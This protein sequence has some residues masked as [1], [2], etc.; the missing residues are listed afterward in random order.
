MLKSCESTT[1]A[2]SVG[3]SFFLLLMVC[4]VGC[5]WHWKRSNTQQLT[6]PSFLQRR[7][8]RKE[9]YTETL[10]IHPHV[11]NPQPE[12]TFQTEDHISA[13]REANIQDNYENMKISPCEATEE[14]EK[15][16]YE[17]NGQSNFEEHI[18]GNEIASH[19]CNFQKPSISTSDVP[20][21]DDIYILP[22]P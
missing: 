3:I 15:E 8:S 10:P 12:M 13:E 21:D 14:I 19:Y 17:N 16:I 9:D 5:I 7:R 2:I 4:G 22:D 20:Q 6:L 11:I 18:Y 1:V